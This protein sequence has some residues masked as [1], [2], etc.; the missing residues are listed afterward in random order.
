MTVPG[1]L[2]IPELLTRKPT[3]EILPG[4][5]A[6]LMQQ[7]DRLLALL[8]RAEPLIPSLPCCG[9]A[10]DG[11][12]CYCPR[13]QLKREI[14]IAVHGAPAGAGPEPWMERERR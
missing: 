12:G 5:L 14:R 10:S 8:V 6:D 2:A 1:R 13:A 9:D 7:R 11:P 4:D 3:V